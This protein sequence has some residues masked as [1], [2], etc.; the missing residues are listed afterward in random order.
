[1]EA[2]SV[3]EL[4]DEAALE[5]QRRNPDI[6]DEVR[7]GSRGFSSNASK[8]DGRIFAMIVKDELVVKL[9]QQRADELIE[10]GAGR[11]FDPGS[12]RLMKQWVSLTPADLSTCT[13]LMGEALAYV[14]SSRS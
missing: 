3:Q 4:Y 12:G 7:D 6:V 1:M 14:S 5:L 11:R 2:S 9:P 10:I 8:T 13:L